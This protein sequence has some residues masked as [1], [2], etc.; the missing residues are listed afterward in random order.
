MIDVR[1]AQGIAVVELAHGKANALDVELCAALSAVLTQLSAERRAVVLTGRGRIFSAGVDLTRLVAGGVAYARAF[2]PVLV[3]AI[4]S[5][6]EYPWPLVAAVNGHAVAGGCVL[7]SAA[8]RCI[9]VDAPVHVGIPELRVGVPFPAA[10]IE[11][12]RETLEPARFRALVLGGATL[13]AAE[14]QA[15][16]LVD[17]VVAADALLPRALSVVADLMQISPDVYRVTKAQMRRPALQRIAATSTEY[18]EEVLSL[19]TLPDVLAVVQA[20]AAKV[21]RK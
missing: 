5:V 10:A 11:I 2:L 3:Q 4:Q 18:G 1:E 6:F 14:A 20:Y 17:E 16:G 12:M 9:I 19:W 7:A 13:N 8:D 21:L 15:W